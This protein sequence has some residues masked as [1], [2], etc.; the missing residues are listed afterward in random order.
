MFRSIV[1][2]ATLI[3]LVVIQFP[4]GGVEFNKRRQAALPDLH[5][6]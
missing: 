2:L 1:S 3:A 4:A 6:R 5:R